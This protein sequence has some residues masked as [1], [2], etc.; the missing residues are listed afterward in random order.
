MTIGLIGYGRFGA[1][2]A[3]LIARRAKVVVYDARRQRSEKLPAGVRRGTIA[4][5][6]R[7]DV[8]VLA[9]PVGELRKVLFRIRSH[10]RAGSLVVDVCAV[11]AVPIR[12]MKQIVPR[13][14]GILGTH[15]FFGPDSARGGLQGLTVVLCPVRIGG[16]Q[17]AALLTELHRKGV[18]TVFMSPDD[19]DRLMAETILLSQYVGRMVNK[20]GATRW[21]PLTRNYSFILSI[22][23]T[24]RRDTPRLFA[25]MVRYNVHGKNLLRELGKAHRGLLREVRQREGG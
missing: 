9:V 10:L 4:E 25:D 13:A 14:V 23:D 19:H 16:V 5:A 2:V 12:W 17:L 7:Q 11:K 22:V 20:T 3:P 8:V 6:A 21:P 1:F 18:E 24:V 15:P